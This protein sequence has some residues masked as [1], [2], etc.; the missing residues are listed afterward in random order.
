[1]NRLQKAGVTTLATI[2][3]GCGVMAGP[4]RAEV[5]AANWGNNLVRA[6]GNIPVTAGRVLAGVVGYD[7][8]KNNWG[9]PVLKAGD[10]LIRGATD[11]VEYTVGVVVP[12]ET[13]DLG[14]QGNLDASIDKAGPVARLAVSAIA[15]AIGGNIVYHNLNSPGASLTEYVWE[16]AAWTAAGSAV[17]QTGEY[18]INNSKPAEK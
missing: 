12:Y 11:Q 18:F 2:V 8:I 5:S 13:N 4:A 14:K 17:N 7:P 6:I 15:G 3:L 10:N 1:M 9:I 16:G